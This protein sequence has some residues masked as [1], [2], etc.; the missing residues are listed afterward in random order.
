MVDQIVL[1]LVVH[2]LGGGR[3]TLEAGCLDGKTS[4]HYRMF[5]LLYA[6]ESQHV[7]E[8]LE[9]VATPNKIKKNLKGYEAIKRTVYQGRGEKVRAFFDQNHMPR[10][11]QAIRNRIR[12]EGFWMR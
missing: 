4:C 3:D 11:E 1:P 7:I 2:A 8:T 9:T 5:P 6:R 10:R 12:S